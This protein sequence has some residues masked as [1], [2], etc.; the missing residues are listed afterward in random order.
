MVS[1]N[2]GARPSP[3]LRY[4]RRIVPRSR[5]VALACIEPELS[6]GDYTPFS[7][8]VRRVQATLL[9]EPGL[10]DAEPALLEAR[11]TNVDEWVEQIE[12]TGAD[13]VGLAAYV[14]SFP[15]FLEVAQRLKRTRPE[16]TIVMGGPSARPAMLN[17]P[18]FAAAAASVDALVLREGDLSFR[19]ILKAGARSNAELRKV[20]GLAV[21]GL[22]GWAATGEAPPLA[23][24]DELPSPVR[25]GLV[26]PG[27]TVAVE[28]F[29]GCPLSCSFCQ[30]GEMEAP[31]AVF[32]ADYLAAELSALL[33]MGAPSAQLVDAALN[34]SSRA[35]K[36]LA[37][38]ERSVGFFRSAKLFSCLYPSH[39]ND[40]HLEFLSAI[41]RPRIDVGLQSFSKAALD[42]VE[43]PFSEARFAQVMAQLARLAE[44]EVEIILGLPGDTPEAFRAT[45]CR[46]LELPCRVRVFH[47]LVLPDAL[48]TRSLPEHA[49]RFDPRSLLLTSC[50]GF[51][52]EAL[53]VE[54]AVLERLAA[55]FRGEATENMWSFPPPHLRGGT[56]AEAVQS[57][58]VRPVSAA[59][60]AEMGRAVRAASA[61]AWSLARAVMVDGE[62]L[63]SIRT[64]EQAFVLEMKPAAAAGRAYRVL[65]GIAFSYRPEEAPEGGLEAPVRFSREGL[66]LLERVAFALREGARRALAMSVPPLGPA[67]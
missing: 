16:R 58:R 22:A 18:P 52:P 51:S 31:T 28:T 45:L 55:D 25:M 41:R 32:S 2:P 14:W 39:L 38:A 42:A 8:G 62:V 6:G 30:W 5:R 46:A 11:S 49:V 44:V 20:P 43:R 53:A 36:N 12:A 64:A 40:S 27:R 13:V 66:R 33:A 34:L 7:F 17:L 60:A 48:L 57:E 61:G 65:D 59:S 63:A 29:R 24:L 19:E 50:T 1:Q 35:F 10:A 23:S 47:C 54:R 67:P 37:E 21:R 26:P 15:T 3:R 4:A 56:A 9:A